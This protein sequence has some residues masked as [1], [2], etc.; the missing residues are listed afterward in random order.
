MSSS[1]RHCPGHGA[2]AGEPQGRRLYTSARRGS[3]PRA[4]DR[5]APHV[6]AAKDGQQ[7]ALER[8]LAR[9]RRR[10]RGGGVER[11]ERRGGRGR[12]LDEALL[13][14]P[15]H[16]E[17]GELPAAARGHADRRRRRV[18]GRA[19]DLPG[20]GWPAVLVPLPVVEGN[21]QPAVGKVAHRHAQAV[22]DVHEAVA[23][24][25]AQ[26]LVALVVALVVA[27]GRACGLARDRPSRRGG[28]GR[29]GAGRELL[30]GGGGAGGGGPAVGGGGRGG[31]PSQLQEKRRREELARG[32]G[33]RGWG[34]DGP[35]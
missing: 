15:L 27:R 17:G 10:H 8:L 13:H 9:R 22:L 5:R 20:D 21:L 11:A 7:R 26:A 4:A 1:A 34:G 32:A 12:E 30:D 24:L 28:H 16:E 19:R 35:G 3:S 31:A 23:G 18:R 29:G 33:K 6:E 2:R 14:E 25:E